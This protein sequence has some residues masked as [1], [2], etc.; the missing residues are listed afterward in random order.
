V[1]DVASVANL[2]SKCSSPP[3]TP[4]HDYSPQDDDT[5]VLNCVNPQVTPGVADGE[6][7]ADD[8]DPVANDGEIPADNVAGE[9]ADVVDPICSVL[10]EP[11]AGFCYAVFFLFFLAIKQSHFLLLKTHKVSLVFFQEKNFLIL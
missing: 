8:T 6:L 9:S 10:E 4:P 3:V 5:D 1:D 11:V 2:D 7:P